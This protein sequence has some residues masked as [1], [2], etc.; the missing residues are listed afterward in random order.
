VLLDVKI[1]DFGLSKVVGDGLSE[2]N[3]T[4]GSPRY[5]A[6]EVVGKGVYDFRADIWSLGVLLYVLLDG[7]FPREEKFASAGVE[8]SELDAAVSK[9]PVGSD[10]QFAVRGILQANPE[11]RAT[12]KQMR[13]HPWFGSATAAGDS[14]PSAET[15][16]AGHAIAGERNSIGENGNASAADDTLP[17]PGLR[18]GL[19]RKRQVSGMV[20]VSPAVAARL[21]RR[22]RLSIGGLVIRPG[23]RRRL[24]VVIAEGQVPSKELQVP[25]LHVAMQ[26]QN[27][28]LPAGL[29]PAR[30]WSAP[31]TLVSRVPAS[32]AGWRDQAVTLQPLPR[33]LAA[34]R[35]AAAAA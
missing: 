34:P 2:A 5:M 20:T 33:P 6:P 31:A 21:A 1:A 9:L 18:K 15:N 23:K 25:S 24:P 27:L 4:V 8:Q 26:R 22:R 11:G 7:R 14:M 28:P 29:K 13:A 12:F 35:E 30:R 3:T 17:M 16:S 10:A 19:R 32:V